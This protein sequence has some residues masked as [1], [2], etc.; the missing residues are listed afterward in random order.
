MI[1]KPYLANIKN[2]NPKDT[3]IQNNNPGSGV[4]SDII[5][6]NY[7]MKKMKETKM[8]KEIFISFSSLLSF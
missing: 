4:N 8:M 6:L 5:K 3:S 1:G 2:T 7:K